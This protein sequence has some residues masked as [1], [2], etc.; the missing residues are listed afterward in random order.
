M[1][2]PKPEARPSASTAR[3]SSS[4]GVRPS[5]SRRSGRTSSR[6]GFPARK[7]STRSEPRGVCT[8][9]PH[10]VTGQED[11]HPIRAQ[12]GLH[13]DQVAAWLERQAVV[14]QALEAEGAVVGGLAQEPGVYGASVHA[15]AG[16]EAVG[17]LQHHPGFIAAE[18]AAGQ[19]LLDE[20]VAG[21]NHDGLGFFQVGQ[22][23]LALQVDLPVAYLR[24]QGGFGYGAQGLA[25]TELVGELALAL[26]R[27]LEVEAALLV[28]AGVGEGAAI[29]PGRTGLISALGRGQV[30]E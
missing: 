27:Q 11:L 12:R 21:I 14:L 22:A 8:S 2:G 9:I 15:Q 28:L 13:L 29:Q 24:G 20:A 10:G 19:G 23:L 25:V 16:L 17:G 30:G 3:P 1:R 7:T 5:A 18:H 26:V 4:S 6:T